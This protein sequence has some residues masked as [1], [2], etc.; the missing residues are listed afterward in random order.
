LFTPRTGTYIIASSNLLAFVMA[1]WTIK[2]FGR[3]PL[4][5]YGH[6]GIAIAHALIGWFIII[7]FDIGIVAMICIFIWIYAN[8]TGP[9]AWVY[10]AE[11]CTDIGQG[12]CLFTLWAVVLIEVLI[13][14]ML[15]SSA[16]QPQGVFF[17]FAGFSAVAAVFIYFYLKETRGLTDK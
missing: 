11:T 2:S 1:I 6:I 8:T 4:L 7:G 16:L 14:P 10:S 5:L 12:V 3:R 9:I 13:V 15:M 17:L